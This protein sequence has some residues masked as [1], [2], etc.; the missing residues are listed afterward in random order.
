MLVHKFGAKL[1]RM[2]SGNQYIY[3]SR[4]KR[5]RKREDVEKAIQL[6]NV[7]ALFSSHWILSFIAEHPVKKKRTGEL[8]K[9]CNATSACLQSHF[10]STD[11]I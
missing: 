11:S 8:R 3:Q 5:R 4:K 10:P 2:K 7:C 6:Y 1:C 9:E